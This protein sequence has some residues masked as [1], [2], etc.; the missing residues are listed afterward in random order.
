M[1]KAFADVGDNVLKDGHTGLYWTANRSTE[2][3]TLA[4]ANADCAARNTYAQGGFTDW[5]LPN[6]VE[7]TTVLDSGDAMN[8]LPEHSWG[9]WGTFWS[10]RL[11]GNAN[12]LTG[13]TTLITSAFSLN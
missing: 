9:A 8:P 1:A 4:G 10:A 3:V 2:T 5:R 11:D 12:R 13:S 7:L 6:M